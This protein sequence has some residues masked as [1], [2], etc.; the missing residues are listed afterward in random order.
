MKQDSF[1]IFSGYFAIQM[2]FF[3]RVDFYNE[4]WY[5]C[6]NPERRADQQENMQCRGFYWLPFLIETMF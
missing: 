1:E 4:L 5:A 2:R 6:K 3:K